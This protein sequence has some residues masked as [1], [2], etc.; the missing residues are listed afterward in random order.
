[1]RKDEFLR[2]MVQDNET[3]SD[4]NKKALYADT[5]EC[6]DIALSQSPADTDIAADKTT[7]GAYKTVE[8]F[9]RKNNRRSVGPFESAEL[10]AQYLGV[11]YERAAKKY[12]KPKPPTVNLDDLL[13]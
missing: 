1:M 5:I 13:D 10:I 4:P 9:A 2:M 12:A 3:E 11:K 8:A 7:E 6:M